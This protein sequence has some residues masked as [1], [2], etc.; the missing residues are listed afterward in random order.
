MFWLAGL[1]ALVALVYASVG[2]GGGSTYTASAGAVGRRLQADPGHFA[3]VQY[4]RRHA[5]AASALCAPDCNLAAG[6]AVDAGFGAA[7]LSRRAGAVEA[8]AVPADFGWRA[9]CCRRLP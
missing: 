8:M 7:G 2:F 6:F 3:A 9:C 1:F 4:H 5:A